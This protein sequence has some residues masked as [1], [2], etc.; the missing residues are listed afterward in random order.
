MRILVTNDD[1]F[2][3]EGLHRLVRVART[4]GVVKVSAPDTERSA[5]SHAMTMRD[6]LRVKQFDW[7][8]GEV[9][10][11]HVD[12]FPSDCVNA[13]LTV[14]WP[15]GCDLVL[16]GINNGPNLGFDATY[17]GTVGGA[18]EGTI[19]GIRSIAV[20]MACFVDGAP[21][22]Y[23]TGERWL[24]ENLADLV[25]LPAKPLTLLNVN[26]PA[27]AYQEIMGTKVASMGQRVYEDRMELRSD[28]WGRPYY[29]QGG[30]AVVS[31]DQPG[32]DVEAV[33]KGYV[34]V[35]P[36]TLDWTDREYAEV[37]RH[38]LAATART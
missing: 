29:W 10:A 36:I 6:P 26:I 4:L 13:G 27:I 31:P 7:P 30:V 21:L 37:I 18:M 1:G 12:G 34:A 16:S 14:A 17:S 22:H 8:D 20:S 38:E 11:F 32:T 23:E 2:R 5:C 25:A 24:L 3:A 9:E 15:D 28:P 19:N 35:T 33:S